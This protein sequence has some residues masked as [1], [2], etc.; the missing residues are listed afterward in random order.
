MDSDDDGDYE[1]VGEKLRQQT[2]FDSMCEVINGLD[3]KAADF[4]FQLS[5][6]RSTVQITDWL[7]PAEKVQI[8]AMLHLVYMRSKQ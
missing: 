6:L 3:P 1:E 2:Y 4:D 8:R 5:N 7:T